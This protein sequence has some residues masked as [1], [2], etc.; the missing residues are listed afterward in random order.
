VKAT[1]Y[2][3]GPNLGVCLL[4]PSV[5]PPSVA[6]VVFEP[7][8]RVLPQSLREVTAIIE[9]PYV[10]VD[11]EATSQDHVDR[12]T[13]QISR[14][15]SRLDEFP[16]TDFADDVELRIHAQMLIEDLRKL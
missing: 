15:R 1:V 14:L 9:M 2:I 12:L 7:E 11:R 16:G 4:E 8:F 13:Q 6:E 10:E 3:L 5:G